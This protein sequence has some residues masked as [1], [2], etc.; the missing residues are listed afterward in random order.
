MK[1]RFTA[2]L[3]LAFCLMAAWRTDAQAA[4][5]QNP[6][7]KPSQQPAAPA[8]KP[9]DANAFPDDT[10]N[11][12]VMPSSGTPALPPGTYG[13]EDNAADSRVRLP[14]DDADPVRS[15]DD[16]V[17]DADAAQTGDS[18]SSLTGLDKL[19]PAPGDDDQ[20]QGKKKKQPAAKEPEHQETS[21]ED[22][23]VGEYYLEIKNWKAAL[24]RF[25]SALVL[26]PDEPE[27]YWG[28]AESARHLGNFAEARGYYQKVALYDP[29]SKH[30]KEAIKALKDPEIA[31]AKA[32][33]PAPAAR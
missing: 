19:L 22:L 11:V 4:P 30:G 2:A 26:T 18:S 31:N 29:D 15:P 23:Q 3:V 33:S 6:P 27:V 32:A 13:G 9:A 25:E 21:A 14:G 17:P 10:S 28:L 5:T 8:G 20:P 12:P 7:A 16:A 24:S 1:R